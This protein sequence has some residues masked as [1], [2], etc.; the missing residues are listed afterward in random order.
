MRNL[1]SLTRLGGILVLLFCSTW[2]FAQTNVTGRVTSG[3]D[4]TGLPGVS[5]VEKGTTNGTVSDA[6]GNYSISVSENSTLV[7]S[8]VGFS[9]QELLVNGR[10][11]INVTLN[12]DVTALSEIVVVGYGQQERKDVTGSVLS[13][14]TEEF[15]SGVITSPQELLVGKV[16]G[17]QITTNSGAPGSASTIRIRG[18]SSLNASNDPLFVIDGFPVDNNSLAGSSNPLASINPNDIE[19]I[20]ILKDASGTAIYGS[21]ASNGVIIVT[22][23]KGKEGK[24]KL[25]YNGNYSVSTP[26][27]YIDV[28]NGNE[29]RAL[30]AELSEAGESGINEDAV[31]L[32]GNENTNWQKEIFR[33]AFS[34]DH[35]ISASGAINEVAYR[36]S[37][38]YTNQQGILKNTGLSRNSL[39]FNI[40]PSLLG[41]ALNINAGFKGSF[42]KQNF[43][44][45]GAVGAAV[46]FDPTQPVKSDD[47][48]FAPYGGYFSWLN[49]DGSPITIATANPV[50]LVNQT[51]NRSEVYRAIGTLQA[52]YAIPFVEGLTANLSMGFD[53]A[54]GDGRDKQNSNAAWASGGPGRLSTYTSDNRST[55]F[56]FYL[57]YKKEID[58]HRFDVT[59]GYS[60]QD[61]SR[62]GTSL[63]RN[64]EGKR[65]TFYELADGDTVAYQNTP[66]PNTL[67]SVFGRINYALNDKYL[68]TATLRNDASSRFGPDNRSGW[69]PS[70]ALGWRINQE[71]FLQDV[72]AVSDLKLRL[73][74]GITGQQDIGP[75]YPYL[76]LVTRSTETAK[77]QFGNTYYT[78]YRPNEFDVAIK[79]EETT[80]YNIGLDFGF[81]NDRITGTF[82]IYQR[83]TRDLLNRIPVPAGS[84]L[85]NYLNTN[86][87]SLENKGYEITLNYKVIDKPELTWSIGANFTHNQNEITKLTRVTDPDYPGLL[88]GGITG[89]VGNTVQ[90]HQVGYPANSFFVFQQVYDASGNPIEGLYVDQTGEGGS[91]ISNDANRIRYKSP[92]PEYLAG[93]NSRV[94]YKDFDFSFS[95]RL[96]LGNYTYNNVLSDRA[97]YSNIFNTNGFLNNVPSAI[98]DTR[99]SNAQYL[100]S[101]YIEDASFFKMDYISAGYSFAGLGEKVKGRIGITVNNA[102]FIT[103]YSGLDPE[104]NR[105]RDANGIESTGIDNNI[106]PRP[107][108]FML[109][110]NLTY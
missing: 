91:V 35:N 18:G 45:E 15:N 4:G 29:Y 23:K 55:L 104:V 52:D 66:N 22:T 72:N 48:A 81:I 44:N 80:T 8:F 39:N 89:G 51:D 75:T 100:S 25:N 14:S 2:M 110:L 50:S 54:R 49:A 43:G 67:I 60:Y 30:I 107:R 76:A 78:T 10:S 24:F 90:N 7:F 68:L 20:N 108:V 69:F 92:N 1:Y 99:F 94:T 34:H 9:S 105:G 79:W 87:G 95:G 37:Y 85:K 42:T 6:E 88:V 103:D 57:N 77:Y 5:I 86:V 59:G 53:I 26:V 13:F 12:S 41:G 19:S 33:N 93:I 96:S 16:A 46:A 82:D 70:V 109:S 106:Y 31:D 62:D 11:N 21:R 56:D 73:S 102:F 101:Y 61:F 84:N 36:V 27:K 63:V 74:Y 97:R 38:G 17:V 47:P 28:L 83:E 40:T 98:D 64:A 3:E 71:S 58:N 65:F 32:L